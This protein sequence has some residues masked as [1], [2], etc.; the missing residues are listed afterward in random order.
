MDNLSRVVGRQVIMR[1]SGFVIVKCFLAAFLLLGPIIAGQAAG[2]VE[3]D[4]R[5]ALFGRDGLE[6]IEL[7]SDETDRWVE[8]LDSGMRY[9]VETSNLPNAA[10]AVVKDGNIVFLE[11]YGYADIEQS[12][13]ADPHASLFR[14]GSVAKIFTWTAVMQLA[15]QGL[16]DLDRDVNEYLDFELP[17][18]IYG[19]GRRQQPLPVTMRHLLSH[20]AGFEDVLEGLFLLQEEDF[21]P[22]R[23]YLVTRIPARIYPPGTVMAYSN[24]GTALAGYIVE[25]VSGIPFGEYIEKHIFAP[26]GMENSSFSQ[27]L[28]DRLADRLVKPYRLVDGRFTG[29]GFEYM[30]SP[31]G[32]LSTT[33]EDMARFMIAHLTGGGAIMGEESVRQMHSLLFTHHTLLGGMAHG[34]MEYTR[35]GHRVV[36]HTGSSMLYDAGFYMLPGTGAGIFMVYSGGDFSGHPGL[37][38]NFMGRFFPPESRAH[39]IDDRDAVPGTFPSAPLALPNS[40]LGGEYQQSRRIETGGDKLVN[41]LSMVMRVRPEGERELTVNFLGSDYR[42]IETERGIYTNLD[43]PTAYPLGPMQ[44]IVLTT[45]PFGRLMLATDGP[46][47][48]IRMPFHTTAGFTIVLIVFAILMSLGTLVYF[49]VRGIDSLF[50]RKALTASLVQDAGPVSLTHD[51]GQSGSKSGSKSGS[52]SGSQSGS[53]SGSQSGSQSGSRPGGIWARR[54]ILIHASL[55]LLMLVSL[56]NSGRPDPVYLLPLSAAG[57]TS[58]FTYLVA[59]LPWILAP[60]SIAV[61]VW[62]VMAWKN[63]WLKKAGLIHYSLYTLSAAGMTWF[64]WFYNSFGL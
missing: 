31:A 9:M 3:T 18:L 25:R 42:F 37:F 55:F 58:P 26:L 43:G 34:F 40:E 21:M 30:P 24:W 47:T 4:R 46:V 50:R 45:D 22:L 61:I 23:E 56:A 20:T 10:I 8:F 7:V 2:H 38:G 28:P 16:I 5:N 15:E 52:Q 54:F 53:K 33:A 51:D 63:R 64:F 48:Y 49:T 6:S 17:G 14:T 13:Q 59:I 32:G 60:L 39:L 41:L 1:K 12:I 27:P 36:Y 57:I 19:M 11:G 62:C 29:G 35:N 44:Y